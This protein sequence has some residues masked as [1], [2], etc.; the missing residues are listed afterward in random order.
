M[1]IALLVLT[2]QSSASSGADIRG[3]WINER[4]SAIIRVADCPSGLC[5]TVVW[6]AP[7]AQRDSTR[8]GITELNGTVV[9]FGFAPASEQRWRGRLFLPDLNRTV[10]ATLSLQSDGRLQ[11]RG[12]ELGGL[13][14]RVQ[15]WS[16][17]KAQ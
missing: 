6:S 15:R 1:I 7:S 4:K 14:C 17:W 12:C 2:M 11:V 5:G 9:M 8:G 10:K 16:R 3:E 13:V